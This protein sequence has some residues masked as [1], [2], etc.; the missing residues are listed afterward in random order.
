VRRKPPRP[1]EPLMIAIAIVRLRMNHVLA[2]TIGAS[3]K[4][5]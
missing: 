3:M 4:P 1:T 2:I 5:A